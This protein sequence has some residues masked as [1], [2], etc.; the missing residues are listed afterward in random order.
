MNAHEYI[1]SKQIQWVHRNNIVLIGS[2]VNRG[3]KAYTQK[4]DDNLFE[5]LM[6]EVKNDLET[7]GLKFWTLPKSAKDAHTF[8]LGASITTLLMI[9]VFFIISKF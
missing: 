8:S 2:K 7:L 3:R 1:L 9:I 4:L 5:P 6:S